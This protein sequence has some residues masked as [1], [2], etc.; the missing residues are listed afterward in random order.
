MTTSGSERTA[1]RPALTQAVRSKF[2]LIDECPFI[3]D[4]VFLDSASGSLRL[5]S[6][7]DVISA[8]SQ[9]PDQINRD[10]PGS[11]HVMETIARGEEDVRTFLGSGG[12]VISALTATAALFRTIRDAVAH[13][14]GTNVVTTSLDHP[15]T[16]DALHR[17]AHVHGKEFRVAAACPRT[18]TVTPDSI[19]DLV[20]SNTAV[21]AFIHGSNVTGAYLDAGT[22]IEEARQINGDVCVI[23]DGVQYAPYAP[24]DVQDLG[25][26]VYVIAPYKTYCKKGIGFALLSERF[27][28]IPHD[29]VL[30][31]PGDD[32][33]LGS[34]DHVNYAAWSTTVDYFNWL[35][36]QFTESRSRRE[37]VVA[38]MSAI[39]DHMGMLLNHLINGS[40]ATPGLR[41][42]D[43]IT[44][45]GIGESLEERSC[46]V[47]MNFE[48]VDASIMAA[49]YLERGIVVQARKSVMSARQLRALG[50]EE[51]GI[52]RVSAAHY[53]SP[54]SIEHFLRTTTDV[55]STL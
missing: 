22:I 38:A 5:K 53:T 45:H 1:F 36:S 10:T 52:V 26:D 24:V 44:L 28:R 46:V 20:D 32:W 9:L 17:W 12:V 7:C 54:D 30:A 41:A 51:G 31:K 42:I 3:G 27:A 4:R 37:R 8:E 13:F 2:A 25:A 35:G 49:K 11:R 16:H 50:I 39:K 34:D 21:I 19:L 43:G 55:T 15:A 18:G 23:I 33:H 14:P 29:R 48:G 40:N 47:A 6:V